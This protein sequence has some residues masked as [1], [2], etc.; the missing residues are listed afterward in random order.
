MR[1]AAAVIEDGDDRCII[2]ELV[3]LSQREG[4]SALATTGWRDE[5]AMKQSVSIPVTAKCRTGIDKIEDYDFDF[6]MFNI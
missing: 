5:N 3:P 2:P 6:S 4:R 1:L